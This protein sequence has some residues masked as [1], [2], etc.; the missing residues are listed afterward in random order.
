MRLFIFLTL[1]A[2]FVVA[3]PVKASGHK[4]VQV[5]MLKSG[6]ATKWLVDEH[7]TVKIQG[8]SPAA[9][10]Y[11]NTQ[12]G[13]LFAYLE[14]EDT[15]YS[16]PYGTY[17]FKVP[18]AVVEGGEEWHEYLGSKSRYWRV[19]VGGKTCSHI[20]AN[21]AAA[22]KAKLNL[23]DLTRIQ[24]ALSY[25]LGPAPAEN[26]GPYVVNVAAGREVGLPLYAINGTKGGNEIVDIAEIDVETPNLLPV[27]NIKRITAAAHARFLKGLLTGEEAAAFEAA[28]AN[29]PWRQQVRALKILLKEKLFYLNN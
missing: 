10:F 23:A 13:T 29:L 7:K 3:N 25:L 12:N 20:F 21:K 1:F 14:G 19:K 2:A 17:T 9:R 16:I 22:T 15:V 4:A 28:S 27:N 18:Q 5:D 26:C 8:I 6:V 24:T 11:Y